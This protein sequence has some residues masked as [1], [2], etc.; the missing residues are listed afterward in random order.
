MLLRQ[1][2]IIYSINCSLQN[3]RMLR[4]RPNYLLFGFY[5][6]SAFHF[7]CSYT[8]SGLLF[9]IIVRLV[10]NFIDIKN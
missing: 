3:E 8:I 1:L 6:S 2:I 7:A 4:L 5:Y 9:M 10:T